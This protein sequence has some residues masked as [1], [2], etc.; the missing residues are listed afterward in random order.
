MAVFDTL[1]QLNYDP[2]LVD[3]SYFNVLKHIKAAKL[4][5]FN[6]VEMGC[7]HCRR[8]RCHD[9]DPFCP[10]GTKADPNWP[11]VAKRGQLLNTYLE[12]TFG[13][14]R[15]GIA[16]PIGTLWIHLLEQ[17]LGPS[18]PAGLQTRDRS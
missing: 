4:S 15:L 1:N 13:R 16:N 14:Q 9:T 18:W 3:F 11:K 6:G 12:N 7:Y 5:Y 2:K 10:K 8:Q 17:V